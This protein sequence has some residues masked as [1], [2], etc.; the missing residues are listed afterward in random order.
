MPSRLRE[1]IEEIREHEA[2]LDFSGGGLSNVGSGHQDSALKDKWLEAFEIC[3]I[4]IQEEADGVAKEDSAV[5]VE[6][7]YFLFT[8]LVLSRMHV[9]WENPIL[10]FNSYP[11]C[12]D[13]STKLVKVH[14]LFQM[15]GVGAIYIADRG[16]YQGKITLEGFLNLRY[17]A[18][19]YL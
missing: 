16:K 13:G 19:K 9:D 14:F 6:D 15:L 18:Q 2:S 5:K 1:F 3:K 8:Y 17:T 4:R 7:E 12:V 10:K 11:I